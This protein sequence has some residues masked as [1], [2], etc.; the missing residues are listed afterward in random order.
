MG[1][2]DNVAQS[3]QTAHRSLGEKFFE[4]Q[5]DAYRVTIRNPG[6]S[7]T[8]VICPLQG[9]VSSTLI[10]SPVRN[11]LVSPSVVVI[12]NA[13]CTTVTNCAAGAGWFSRF[14]RSRAPQPGSNPAKYAFEA[15]WSPPTSLTVDSQHGTYR[16]GCTPTCRRAL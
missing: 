4:G 12:E 16:L 11:C 14:S 6:W 10:T 1:V 15:G 9:K 5:H 8:T 2:E 7:P 13:P 3:R